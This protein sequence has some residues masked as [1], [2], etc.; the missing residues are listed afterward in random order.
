M[1]L[2]IRIFYR[3]CLVFLYGLCMHAYAQDWEH[4]RAA[5]PY[6]IQT[7][8]LSEPDSQQHRTLI[9]SEPPP[10][11]TLQTV[12]AITP[13]FQSATV[14][15]TQ[16]G[17]DGWVRDIVIDLPPL[18]PHQLN[19]IIDQL[20]VQ[21]FTTS[22]KAY[23]TPIPSTYL[24]PPAPHLNLHITSG[25]LRL[26]LMGHDKTE[27]WGS[28]IGLFGLA[29]VIL[30][31]S[32]FCLASEKFLPAL[33]LAGIALWI[34]IATSGVLTLALIG[35]ILAIFAI[36]RLTGSHFAQAGVSAL[37]ALA[38]LVYSISSW[39]ST[40]QS[41]ATLFSSIFS[42]DHLSCASILD[43][44][45]TGVF[46]STTPGLVLWSFSRNTPLELLTREIREFSLDSDLIIG[47]ISS[48]DQL[49]IIARERTTPVALLPPL[50][51][52]T[53]LQLAGSREDELSQSY[54]RNNLLAGRYDPTRRMDWAPIYLSPRL[55]DTE[56]GSLLNITDQ[57]LKGWSAHDT[58]HYVNFKYPTPATYPFPE[59]LMTLL[60]TS[61][62][63]YNWN[64]KGTGYTSSM[65]GYEI[66]ALNKT[67]SLPIDYLAQDN[68]KIKDAEDTAYTYYSGMNDPNLIRVVQ[69]A[70]VYQIFHHF[71]IRPS[72]GA[73]R[74]PGATV[75]PLLEPIQ[76]LL[77]SIA[78]AKDADLPQARSDT[79]GHLAQEILDFRNNLRKL[80]RY[81]K[82]GSLQLTL[83]SALSSRDGV[84][85]ISDITDTDLQKGLFTV[86]QQAQDVGPYFLDTSTRQLMMLLYRVRSQGPTE[87]WIH[88]PSIVISQG[89]ESVVGGHNLSSAVTVFQADEGVD[90]GKVFVEEAEGKRVIHYNPDDD[91]KMGASVREAARDETKNGDAI[92]ASVEQSLGTSSEH[93]LN[94]PASLG[95]NDIIHPD[96]LR[97][98]EAVHTPGSLPSMGW[99]T[100]DAVVPPSDVRLLKKLG[101]SRSRVVL[102][103]NDGKGTYVIS[104]PPAAPVQAFSTPSATDAFVGLTKGSSETMVSV[105]FRGFDDRQA[106][107]FLRNLESHGSLS[108][109]IASTEE[110]ISTEELGAIL[111]AK[112]DLSK[113]EVISPA[114]LIT[115][116][117]GKTRQLATDLAIPARES[118]LSRIIVKIRI[119][120]SEAFEASAQMLSDLNSMVRSIVA[121]LSEKD[122]VQIIAKELIH[123]L[124]KD[125][126]FASAQAHVQHDNKTIFY[127]LKKG[128][129]LP[130]EASTL[131]A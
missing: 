14:Q 111:D 32:F 13:A 26:W 63:T 40:H 71:G 82:D 74:S 109:T 2:F 48:S 34:M 53:V 61:E 79:D 86:M 118:G 24:R 104:A 90:A 80:R 44:H 27:H 25:D 120:L 60:G 93:H 87:R 131:S 21:L 76:Q 46:I 56:Y 50:R 72:A 38:L 129:F 62:L 122:D 54:E 69:Y 11:I 103:A 52:E 64:T 130:T 39:R 100:T 47:A 108:P 30:I 97:G 125:R 78:E 68:P 89:A 113:A 106:E 37:V 36:R 1:K 105:H 124:R 31:I 59:A 5:F 42:A 114:Q 15:E 101:G 67:G 23:I 7:V 127:V 81:D 123:E 128:P 8:A 55:I 119:T 116:D 75:S 6:H 117:G 9:V 12:M 20:Q 66:Y 107:G 45:K 4:F 28:I 98:L 51:T 10:S 19:A 110:F 96:P 18:T 22:Y 65:G 126:R 99:H 84:Q 70:A 41:P 85:A 94:L 73:A 49:A 58:V 112:Y 17:V 88:T 102:V 115:Q 91:L 57:L 35:I 92:R 33:F 29:I 43:D 95:I 16:M 3:A 77:G 121:N 83:A